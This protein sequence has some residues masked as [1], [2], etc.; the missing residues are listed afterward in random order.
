MKAFIIG[1][2]VALALVAG[3]AAKPLVYRL[4]EDTATLRSAP[5][6]EA[7]QNNCASCHS[8]DYISTQ[9]PG[10]GREFWEG[11][12]HKMIHSYHAPISET[13]SKAIIDYLS[14]VY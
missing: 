11:E 6:M 12:V 4:P 3:A 14:R 7:A 10:R 9:P 13:D 2:S 5:D 1:S 8:V